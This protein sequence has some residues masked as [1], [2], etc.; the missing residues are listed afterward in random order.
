MHQLLRAGEELTSADR[1][2]ALVTAVVERVL[3]RGRPARWLRGSWLGHPVHPLVVTVPLGAWSSSA[4][5]RVAGQEQQAR[6]LILVGLLT[7]P[8]AVL[9]GLAELP[10]LDTRQQRVALVHAGS[11][12]V[13]SVLFLAAYRTTDPRR[14]AALGLTALAAAGLGGAFGGHLTYALGA[15][16][17][18]W[19]RPDTAG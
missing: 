8:P 6:R 17:G 18:R 14:S 4:V 7:V 16:V 5:L 1:P 12:T 13:G 9:A 11:N 10:T 2:A 3:G 15:G 19:P